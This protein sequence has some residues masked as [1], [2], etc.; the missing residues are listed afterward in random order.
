LRRVT[1]KII[2]GVTGS[3]EEEEELFLRSVLLT[4]AVAEQR[5][6]S[7]LNDVKQIEKIFLGSRTIMAKSSQMQ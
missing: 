1:E 7:V 2:Q 5:S 4:K 6:I 3:K